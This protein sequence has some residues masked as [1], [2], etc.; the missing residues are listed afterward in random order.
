MEETR[1]Q[2]PRKL[3]MIDRQI[4]RRLGHRVIGYRRGRRLEAGKVLE[5]LSIA[6]RAATRL[7]SRRSSRPS[8]NRRGCR[9]LS[10][11]AR[12]CSS[13]MPETVA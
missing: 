13:V 11:A 12:R 8:A 6:A 10:M 3:D 4:T 7:G 9:R 2:T 5:T 1:R